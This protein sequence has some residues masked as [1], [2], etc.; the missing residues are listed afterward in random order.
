MTAIATL[1]S[2]LFALTP[3]L[4][5]QE[6][7]T[8]TMRAIS[9]EE[10]F[11]LDAARSEALAQQGE[12]VAQ[13]AEAE[14]LAAAA[15]R[16]S[17]DLDASQAGQQHSASSSRAYLR[18]GYS[19]F[20]GMRDYIAAKAASARTDAAGLD[21]ARARQLLY[22]GTAQ[23]YITLFESQRELAIRREQLDVTARR[24]GELQGRVD[25]GRSRRSE[26]VAARTQLAQDKA[27]LL[28]SSSGERLAQQALKFAT[29]LEED[30]LPAEPEL[31]GQGRLDDYLKASLSRPDIAARRKS[32]Q[33]YSFL[34]D[35]EARGRWPS[36]NA[37]ADYYVLRDPLP[38]PADRWDAGLTLTMPL[39]TGGAVPARKGA[40]RSA[41]RSAELGLELASRQA[42][43]EVRSAYDEYRYL[44][45]QAAAL[46]EALGLARENA[47][48]Q[49]DDYKLGLVT[50]LDVLSALNAV[51][52][53]RLSLA[54]AR[55][56]E[57]LALVK[58]ETAA[59]LEARK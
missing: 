54:A 35:I 40:A 8:G 50:N 42:M 19:V 44:A 51:Q 57:A 47:S 49:Q 26:L 46:E 5:A 20:S 23:A 22:L 7:S 9:L 31:R 36:V 34:Y 28:A 3:P 29:G 17:L 12:Y 33:Q 4:G 55:A 30:L 58:L 32:L 16:P 45:L 43:S 10:A 38:D 59:G 15:F 18:A 37:Y 2:A 13:L 27:S 39:Y 1:I 11:S 56:G 48:L 41:R 21:L 25:L 53:V 52:Q 14:K 6:S 24:I